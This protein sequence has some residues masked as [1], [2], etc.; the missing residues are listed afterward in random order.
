[1]KENQRDE[2]KEFFAQGKL[3]FNELRNSLYRSVREEFKDRW[4]DYYEAK[5]NGGEGVDLATLKA[6]LVAEQKAALEGRRDEACRE[7]RE[8]RKVLYEQ[9]LENQQLARHDLHDRQNEGLDSTV[10]LELERERHNLPPRKDISADFRVAAVEV[11]SAPEDRGV[12]KS[13]DA[14]S[15]NVWTSRENPGLKS[16]TDIAA[17][18]GQG[19]GFAAISFL[20]SLVDGFVGA[21]PA[22]KARQTEPDAPAPNPFDAVIEEGRKRQRNEQEEADRDW[23]RRQRSYGE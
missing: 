22:P 5:R 14:S 8:S 2:R 20:E 17:G 21:K 13:P 10:F 11:A 16:E 15:A 1:L 12:V 6:E 7:L 19:L 4:S 18:I 23:R 3:E 9:L